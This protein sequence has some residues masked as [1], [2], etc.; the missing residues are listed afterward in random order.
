MGAWGSKGEALGAEEVGTFLDLFCIMIVKR[1]CVILLRSC[2]SR[3]LESANGWLHFDDGHQYSSA[4]G[5]PPLPELF[6]CEAMHQLSLHMPYDDGRK[7]VACFR[8]KF[9]KQH[10]IASKVLGPLIRK[11]KLPGAHMDS[12][13]ATRVVESFAKYVPILF[14]PARPFLTPCILCPLSMLF[15]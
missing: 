7:A 1:T 14:F 11:Y 2:V 13:A 5:F 9:E 4:S 12:Y 10:V 6:L 15:V 8:D 3:M